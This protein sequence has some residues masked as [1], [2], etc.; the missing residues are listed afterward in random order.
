M[1]IYNRVLDR[2]PRKEDKD[3][4][5]EFFLLASIEDGD[6]VLS[7]N[8]AIK[9]EDRLNKYPSPEFL[10]YFGLTRYRYAVE[11]AELLFLSEQ[12]EDIENKIQDFRECS[13]NRANT[14]INVSTNNYNCYVK[15]SV[16]N[17]SVKG[18]QISEDE[19][20]PILAKAE[21]PLYIEE[22]HIML[23]E[24]D[25]L[26]NWDDFFNGLSQRV[27]FKESGAAALLRKKKVPIVLMDYIEMSLH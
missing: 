16:H 26:D 27:N 4:V 15:L 22:A 25:N 23:R 21:F 20:A 11:Q 5:E 9:V 3:K 12:R 13:N 8:E 18:C 17:A 1:T 7:E 6:P 2:T 10:D 14:L 19:L 24:D